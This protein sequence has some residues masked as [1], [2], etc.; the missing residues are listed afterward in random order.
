MIRLILMSNTEA[1]FQQHG[2]PPGVNFA[3]RGDLCPLGECS[4]LRSPRLYEHSI[5]FR[6]M[7]GR[8]ENFTLRG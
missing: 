7:E 4:P 6:R 3:P 5:L 8:T 2:L 1:S